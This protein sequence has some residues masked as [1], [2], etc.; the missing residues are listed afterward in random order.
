MV[1]RINAPTAPQQPA[2]A[3][4]GPDGVSADSELLTKI[5]ELAFQPL[6][7][8][9]LR[10][11][12]ARGLLDALKDPHSRYIDARYMA[13][14]NRN[15][16]GRVTGIGVQLGMDG[17]RL[18]VIAPLPDS[19]AARAG[20]RARDIIET[21]DGQPTAGVELQEAVRRVLGK[22][23]EVV[24]LGVKHADGRAETLAIT[25]GVVKIRSVRGFGAAADR[26]EFVLDPEHNVGYLAI[27]QFSAETP[28]ELKAAIDAVKGAGSRG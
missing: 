15:T 3:G 12:A 22:E 18:I 1:R 11:G 24:R 21:I 2:G 7:E 19:P 9:A 10:Q 23:G 13:D 8:E 16:G 26:E 4:A 6:D 20:V 5:R 25:R 17:P 14:L 27:Q 28:A